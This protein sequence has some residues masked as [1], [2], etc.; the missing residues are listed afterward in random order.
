MTQ[1]QWSV[2]CKV[3]SENEPMKSVLISGDVAVAVNGL[4]DTF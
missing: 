3:E 1:T 2:V 4:P